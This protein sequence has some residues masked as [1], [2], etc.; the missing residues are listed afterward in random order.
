MPKLQTVTVTEGIP[1]DTPVAELALGVTVDNLSASWLNLPDAGR[2]VPPWVHGFTTSFTA[3]TPQARVRWLT[4]SGIT[5]PMAG[6]GNATLTMTTEALPFNPGVVVTQAQPTSGSAATVSVQPP[7]NLSFVSVLSFNLAPGATGTV[8]AGVAAQSI[9]IY[10]WLWSM[11]PALGT[12]GQFFVGLKT[13][14]AV[15]LDQLQYTIGGTAPG[16]LPPATRA[17][18]LPGIIK[19]PA[20]VGLVHDNSSSS[21]DKVNM[22]SSIFYLQF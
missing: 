9:Y 13:S 21:A 15:E 11:V 2:Y 12:A 20:G 10:G 1:A 7:P 19:L 22:A 4:P 8:V 16:A 3:A 6:T 14:A 5:V 17:V 18:M